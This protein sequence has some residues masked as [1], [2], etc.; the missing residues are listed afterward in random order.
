MR[1]RILPILLLALML[2]ACA[3]QS[4]RTAA[5]SADGRATP[6]AAQLTQRIAA[7]RDATSKLT[8]LVWVQLVTS[9]EDRRTDAALAIER[10]DRIRVDAMDNL[11]DV[12][13]QAGSDGQTGWLF[14]PGKEKL[15]EGRATART[16]KRLVDFNWE[17]WELISFVAGTPP[18]AEDSQ[19]LQVG[20]GQFL[21]PQ[22][23]LQLFLD[24]GKGRVVRCVRPAAEGEGI[25]YE[26]RF[27]DYRRAGK[28]EFPHRMEAVF[29]ARGARLVVEYRDVHL[30]NGAGP[31]AFLSPAERA[32][33]TVHLNGER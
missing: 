15:Y 24:G 26:V 18:L 20:Q 10:P 8:G 5:E 7:L 2:G 3:K 33:K 32:G 4:P 9:E 12:W 6:E 22:S 19:I 21:A 17:P 25:D 30:G 14:L 29:P 31:S 28:V 1:I 11:A 27:S 13:A 16:L 23:R